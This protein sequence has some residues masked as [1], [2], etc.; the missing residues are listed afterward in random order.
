MI[1]YMTLTMIKIEHMH[2]ILN[3]MDS[4]SM[5]VMLLV[6]IMPSIGELYVV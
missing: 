6:L 3:R 1:L 2:K 4:V 5:E